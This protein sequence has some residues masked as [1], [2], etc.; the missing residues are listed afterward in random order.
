V[1]VLAVP[2]IADVIGDRGPIA[3]C[4]LAKVRFCIGGTLRGQGHP[5]QPTMVA[6]DPIAAGSVHSK[7][8]VRLARSG[9][10]EPRHIAAID[11][12]CLHCCLPAS[13]G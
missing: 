9:Q 10:P 3:E 11:E 7:A 5:S 8:Q 13:R 2:Y 6:A 12:K 1:N 4:V